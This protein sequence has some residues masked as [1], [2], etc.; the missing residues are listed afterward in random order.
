MLSFTVLAWP[1]ETFSGEVRRVAHSLEVSTR[2]MA[3]ELDVDNEDRR[4]APGMYATVV[5]IKQRPEPSLFVPIAAVAMT[6]ERIFV[7]R[8]TNGMTE[9]V[10]VERGSISGDL[11]EIFGDL[12]AGDQVA[13]R[14]TDELREGVN[15]SAV[16]AVVR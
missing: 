11:L 10:N 2:T 1:G 14:G 5:W 7:I 6:T 15:V 16:A 9:Y 4:L 12:Q 3:V 8:I 13:I